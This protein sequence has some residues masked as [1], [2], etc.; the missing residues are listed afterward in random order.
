MPTKAPDV[1]IEMMGTEFPVWRCLHGGP[2]DA[3]NLEQTTPHPAMDWPRIRKRNLSLLERLTQLYGSCAVLAREGQD[4]V[5]MIR[6]YPK[7]ACALPGAH[8]L[9]L[10]QCEPNGPADAFADAGLPAFEQ[11]QDKTLTIH[12]LTVGLP[13]RP[14]GRYQRKGIATRMVREL[15]RWAQGRGWAAIEAPAYED[16]LTLYAMTGNAGRAFWERLGYTIATTDVEQA[17]TNDSDFTRVLKQEALAIGLKAQAIVNR[18]T[19]RRELQT[20]GPATPGNPQ[21]SSRQ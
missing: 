17:F 12:C 16:L 19:M 9:C 14:G 1:T 11:I 3:E 15:E 18:Y 20:D 7:A 21:G 10:Q 6:F 8:G 4:V 5:G 2:I 13:G